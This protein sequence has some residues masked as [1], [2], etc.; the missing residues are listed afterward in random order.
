MNLTVIYAMLIWKMM[1][2]TADC[3]FFKHLPTQIL[4]GYIVLNIHYMHLHSGLVK[5]P[6]T[7]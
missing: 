4:Q 3:N 1:D 7:A 5:G 2:D 6:H